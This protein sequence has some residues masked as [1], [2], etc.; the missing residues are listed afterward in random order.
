MVPAIGY[1]LREQ[2]RYILDDPAINAVEITFERADD[3]LRV[4]RYVGNTDFDQVS[5]HTLKLSVASPDAPRHDYLV[6]LKSIA[7]EN[8]AATVSDHLGFTHN[9]NHD[10]EMG[11]FAPPPF[12]EEALECTCRNLDLIQDYLGDL[13]FYIENIAYLFR[14]DGTMSEAEFLAAHRRPDHLR[15]HDLRTVSKSLRNSFGVGQGVCLLL[16]PV[17]VLTTFYTGTLLVEDDSESGLPTSVDFFPVGIDIRTAV[18]DSG[19]VSV[20]R[21]LQKSGACDWKKLSQCC[22]EPSSDLLKV[23]IDLEQVG[24]AALC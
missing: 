19:G 18:L 21:V 2:N 12:T 11:H 3:P 8:N 7:T 24:L 4:D 16:N 6:A 15:F 9:G 14:F 17:H 23:F 10:V 5:V 1:A 22:E 20:V 13:K